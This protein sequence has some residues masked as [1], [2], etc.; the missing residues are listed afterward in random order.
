MS[1]LSSRLRFFLAVA[2]LLIA[3]MLR[4]WDFTTLPPGYAATEITDVQIAESV[5]AGE[6]SV[7]YDLGN[8]G[9]EGLYHITQALVAAFIGNGPLG[10]RMLSVWINLLAL[11]L[12][13]AVGRRLFGS[14]A[15]LGAM[16]LLAVSFYPVLL[17]RQITPT[18]MIPF[19]VAVVLL[20]IATSTPI[21]RRRR[22]SGD[23]TTTA[24]AL[25][26]FLGVSIYIHPIGLLLILMSM[27]FI[28]YMIRSRQPMSRRRIS[29]LAF[30]VLL[31]VIL[32]MPYL[33]SSIR[34]PQLGGMERLTGEELQFNAESIFASVQ[35]IVIDGDENPLN[36]LPGQALFD[37]LSGLLIL[38]GFAG[39]VIRWR[40]PKYTLILVA[41]VILMPVF[42]MAGNAP[43]FPNYA[44]SLPL[45]A[46]FFGLGLATLSQYL[47]RYG[48]YLAVIFL[49]VFVGIKADAL[50][51][52]LFE[53]WGQSDAVQ[54]VY[55]GRLG[56]LALHVDHTANTIPTVVCGWRFNDTTEQIT[57][58]ELIGLMLNRRNGDIRYVNCNNALIMTNGGERQQIILPDANTLTTTNPQISA[59]LDQ[60]TW[61]SDLP[62][63]GVLELD[64]E[65][66]LADQVGVFTVSAP[67]SY[68]PEVE[69]ASE[70]VYPPISFSNNLTFLGYVPPGNTIYAPGE[71]LTLVTY[72]RIQEGV[73]PS[74]LR[75]FTH[76]LADPGASPPA[77]TDTIH[78]DSRRLQSRDVF[79]Q[80]TQVPLPE[81][82]PGGTYT[83]SIGAYQD[84]SD[85]RLD[86]L[87]DG[88]LFGNRL[89]LYDITVEAP[90]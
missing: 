52:T 85:I 46:L 74:D 27:I 43:Y 76:V 83:L 86:I 30:A 3:V 53:D 49:A 51:R 35:G 90:G 87:Q 81:S 5:R 6:I 75:L 65:N 68:S 8:K 20:T 78:L 44:G 15:G 89:L 84:T 4:L 55:N 37:P 12:V 24:T 29:Y 69:S 38:V 11:A 54:T 60:G 2:L 56:E 73:V 70:V 47:K 41:S 66:A 50:T 61:L 9:R 22:K 79:L 57:D 33:I 80:A 10:Y 42:L 32:I 17:S 45:L 39:A 63:Q 25:G 59:W 21:Y 64:V 28:G 19:L 16:A 18:T 34:V 14:V 31:M 7:F 72:W 26:F 62:E 58:A 40:E 67:A 13:Y 36:N 1:R 77:N 48:P 88:Q 82:L 71:T 23:T